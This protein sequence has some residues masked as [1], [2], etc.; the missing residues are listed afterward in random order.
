M[1]AVLRRITVHP[2][3]VEESVQRIEHG[4]MPLLRNEPGFVELYVV[5]VGQG[6]GVSISI[7]ATRADAEA[8]NRKSLEWAKE[9]I[10]P[11]AQ[12]PAEIVGVGE[13]LLHQKKGTEEERTMS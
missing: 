10:F 2:H 12:G 3:F 6:E 9:Q 1:Y 13:I 4:L 8:G 7:F 5:Q 11:L